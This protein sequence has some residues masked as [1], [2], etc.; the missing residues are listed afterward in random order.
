MHECVVLSTCPNAEIA[1]RMA[2]RLVE[3]R[4]AACINV[5]PGIQ[6]YYRWNGVIECDSEHLLLIKTHQARLDAV[7]KVIRDISPYETP[8]FLV[9]PVLG[10]SGD[11][12]V[13]MRESLGL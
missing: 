5:A 9:L 8:E 2:R 7:E 3:E 6:S 12:L 11:Y 4:L 10:A 13:W 1:Q